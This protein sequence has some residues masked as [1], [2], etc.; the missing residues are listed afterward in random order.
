[1]LFS[2]YKIKHITVKNRIVF[3]PVV[4]MGWPVNNRVVEKNLEHYKSIARGG[5]GL[6]ITEA[7]CVEETARLHPTQLGIWDDSFIDGIAKIADT[8]HKEGLAVIAQIHHAGMQSVSGEKRT[9][10]DY[11][12]KKGDKEIKG[13][14]LALDEIK[15]IEQQFV[16]AAIRCKKAGMDGIEL[17]GAHS[18]LLSYF[19][20][21]R[22]NGRTDEYGGSVENRTRL[23]ID[24]IK[25]IRSECGEDFIIGIRYGGAM[26]TLEDGIRA[27]QLFEAAGCDFLHVSWGAS[28][29]EI[30]EV[31]EE[32]SEWK[33]PIYTAIKVKE[34]VNIPVIA[35]NEVDTSERAHKLVDGGFVDFVALARPILADYDWVNKVKRGETPVK[36]FKCKPA[37][38]W[39]LGALDNCPA[40]KTA[41]AIE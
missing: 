26:T 34:N 24:I 11:V 4:C 29:S 15:H 14:G 33:S 13:R 19:L 5:V 25:R 32:Y 38:R 2:E 12:I 39:F 23:P 16:D 18:Y 6:I 3:P 7:L 31:P 27:G 37:C 40:R 10:S 41:K 1:M 30:V 28:P 9:P 36:C 35:V 20:S 8:V 17:H 21:D 22:T